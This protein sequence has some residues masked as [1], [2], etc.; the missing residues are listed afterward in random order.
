MTSATIVY[1]KWD[2]FSILYSEY[3]VKFELLGL[4][5]SRFDEIAYN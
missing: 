1:R 5:E 3:I 2:E 4:S